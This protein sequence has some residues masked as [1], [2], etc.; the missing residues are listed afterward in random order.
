MLNCCIGHRNARL[1]PTEELVAEEDEFF[2]AEEEV[3]PSNHSAW[4][5][6]QGRKQ[7]TN[8]KLLK[9]GEILYVPITQVV[10]CPTL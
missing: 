9:T 4:N 5:Q 1:A 8:M 3:S 6:P 7:K 2:D 10:V